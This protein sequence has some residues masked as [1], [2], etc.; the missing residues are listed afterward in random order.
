MGC[1]RQ[2][3]LTIKER[4]INILVNAGF[5]LETDFWTQHGD[6]RKKEWDLA[7]WGCQAS[8]KGRTYS[9]CSWNT[10]TAIVKAGGIAFD[11]PFAIA[12]GI[13]ISAH[14]TT[15]AAGLES[16]GEQGK[17]SMGKVG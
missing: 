13:E 11:I 10:M 4:L 9:I 5:T 8:Y 17:L 3:R 12:D 16:A 14:D 6:Y 7:V 15:S 2:P 1:Y